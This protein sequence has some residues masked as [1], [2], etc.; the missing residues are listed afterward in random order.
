MTIHESK[1]QVRATMAAQFI[2]VSYSAS[3]ASSEGICNRALAAVDW[4]Q[5]RGLH[6]YQA[7]K[8]WGEIPLQKLV[9]A[10][11][12]AYPTIHT[13]PASIS[14]TYASHKQQYDIIFVPLLAFDRG[15]FRL[16]RGAGWYDQF[17]VSQ[18]SALKIG[19]GYDFCEQVVLPREPHDVPLDCV[20]TQ[21]KLWRFSDRSDI[22][23]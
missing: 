1:Q 4:Q 16:G 11:H 12:E 15:G 7:Q 23:L 20:I 19:V 3:L 18:K 8:A 10:L 5:V 21:S 6:Y 14:R 13:V 17:L 22:L 9:E 2:G